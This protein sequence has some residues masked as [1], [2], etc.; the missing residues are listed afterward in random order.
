MNPKAAKR[1]SAKIVRFISESL[2]IK[3]GETLQAERLKID[4][5]YN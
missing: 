4:E 1:A 5:K 3:I 2:Q